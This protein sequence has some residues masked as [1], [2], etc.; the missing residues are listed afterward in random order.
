MTDHVIIQ[1]RDEVITRLKAGV[2]SVSNR[3]YLKHEVPQ[4]EELDAALSPAL[5]V[6]LGD[7]AD[8]RIAVN[9]DSNAPAILEDINLVFFV[10]C[11]VKAD[12]DIEKTAYNLRGEVEATLLGSNAA[13]TLGAKVSMLT[14][15]SGVNNRD[16]SP[17][18]GAYNAQLQFEAKITH[19]E[20][21]PT[22]FT[23]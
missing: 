5:V 8:E 10:S 2:T 4:P 3:V 20:G 23:Y 13:L 17:D 18:Q 21:Q 11:L 1:V 12:G 14:R 15:V 19:L 22:S 16:D 9:G 6:W 7:D